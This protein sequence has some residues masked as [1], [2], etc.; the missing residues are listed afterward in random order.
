MVVDIRL[1]SI[2]AALG[3]TACGATSL[4]FLDDAPAVEAGIPDAMR[5]G[6]SFAHILFVETEGDTFLGGGDDAV[7]H[8]TSILASGATATAMAFAAGAGD[9]TVRKSN[10]STELGAI[11]S[12]YDVVVMLTRPPASATNP[13]Q[14]IVLTDS[15]PED[16]GLPRGTSGATPLT[17]TPVGNELGFVFASGLGDHDLVERVIA[18]LGLLSQ[19]PLASDPGDCMCYLATD[20]TTLTAAC[21]IGGDRTTL[22]RAH[23]PCAGAG[24]PDRFDENAAWLAAFGPK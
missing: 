13:Y 11:L 1:L 9:R 4:P 12:A 14:E 8:T 6:T 16:F 23:D 24:A 5:H 2:A 20:C 19:I 22:D 15:R 17:C 21:A 10:I 3:A 18:S 7:D